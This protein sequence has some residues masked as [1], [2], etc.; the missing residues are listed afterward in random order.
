MHKH[1]LGG[2]SLTSYVPV[3]KKLKA[4]DRERW[5]FPNFMFQTVSCHL[6]DRHSWVR[7]GLGKI[8]S[9]FRKNWSLAKTKAFMGLRGEDTPSGNLIFLNF[10][11]S[12]SPSLSFCVSQTKYS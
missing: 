7:V 11:S 3:N 5:D 1:V 9:V 8:V 10:K 6:L 2:R 12:K 4:E